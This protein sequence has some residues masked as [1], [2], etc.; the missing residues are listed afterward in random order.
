VPIITLL[1]TLRRF[2]KFQLSLSALEVVAEALPVLH[3]TMVVW[4]SRR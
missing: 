1:K 3:F 4:P 2:E